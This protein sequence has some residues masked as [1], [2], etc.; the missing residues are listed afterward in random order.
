[1]G[2]SWLRGFREM[3]PQANA[4]GTANNAYVVRLSR[5]AD[6]SPADGVGGAPRISRAGLH[7]GFEVVTDHAN[8]SCFPGELRPPC[9]R[10]AE[11][12]ETFSAFPRDAALE[13]K[14]VR[15]VLIGIE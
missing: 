11:V 2:S 9:D 14:H 8:R 1:M 13:R 3:V 10:M 15:P 5:T 6:H 7:T 12:S 4:F